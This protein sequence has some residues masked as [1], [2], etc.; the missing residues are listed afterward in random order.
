MDEP[1]IEIE[2]GYWLTSTTPCWRCGHPAAFAVLVATSGR[3]WL[4]GEAVAI[5]EP[6]FVNE[7]CDLPETTLAQALDLV[8]S[9]CP[10]DADDPCDY[11]RNRCS[12]CEAFLRD[13]FL[14][15]TGGALIAEDGT[16]VPGAFAVPVVGTPFSLSD[17]GVYYAEVRPVLDAATKVD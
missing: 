3:E 15:K 16:P 7:A 9:M 10:P 6:I 4:D 17:R 13:Y 14:C 5:D 12:H 8:T 1:A 2:D 11:L